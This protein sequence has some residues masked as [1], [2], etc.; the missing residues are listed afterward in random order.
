LYSF[1]IVVNQIATSKAF[2]KMSLNDRNCRL[3]YESESLKFFKTYSKPACEYEC[4]IQRAV[5][6]CLCKPWNIPREDHEDTPYCD[7]IGNECFNTILIRRTSYTNCSCDNDCQMISYSIYQKST[8][9]ASIPEYCDVFNINNDFQLRG[10]FYYN[11][12]VNGDPSNDD[13]LDFCNF[14]VSKYTNVVEIEMASKYVTRSILEKKFLFEN[15]LASLGD[16][17]LFAARQGNLILI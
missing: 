3:P 15:Q 16:L 12:L 8:P 5:E 10:I 11:K 6:T 17:F 13:R 14:F 4:V 1:S 2:E 9:Y 7:L